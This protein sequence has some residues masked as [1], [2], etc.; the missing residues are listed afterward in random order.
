MVTEACTPHNKLSRQAGQAE[1]DRQDKVNKKPD[2][3]RE[4]DAIE[5]LRIRVENSGKIPQ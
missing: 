3:M 1:H 5:N 2:R 4:D